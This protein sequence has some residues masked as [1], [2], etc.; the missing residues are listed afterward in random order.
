MQGNPRTRNSSHVCFIQRAYHSLCFNFARFQTNCRNGSIHCIQSIQASLKSPPSEQGIRTA[1]RPTPQDETLEADITREV[2]TTKDTIGLVVHQSAPPQ[3]QESIRKISTLR[4]QLRSIRVKPSL[5][6]ERVVL[7]PSFRV[8]NVKKE[9]VLELRHITKSQWKRSVKEWHDSIKPWINSNAPIARHCC[10]AV[11]GRAEL[12]VDRCCCCFQ[13]RSEMAVARRSRHA[14]W[15]KRTILHDDPL[16]LDEAK[17]RFA[18]SLANSLLSEDEASGCS[19]QGACFPSSSL[20]ARQTRRSKPICFLHWSLAEWAWIAAVRDIKWRLGYFGRTVAFLAYAS[21]G[22]IGCTCD[23][24]GGA[25]IAPVNDVSKRRHAHTGS[26]SRSAVS[27]VQTIDG[28]L[29]SRNGSATEI[30]QITPVHPLSCCQESQYHASGSTRS[31]RH[32]P[33][34]CP[35]HPMQGLEDTYALPISPARSR[36]GVDIHVEGG[37]LGNVR[38]WETKFPG[39]PLHTKRKSNPEL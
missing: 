13:C 36:N 26:E 11:C 6:R 24:H 15:L 22:M 5:T 34:P 38:T 20:C 10:G 14:A 27:F 31:S 25:N 30:G 4:P 9:V 18:T 21:C 29:R 16:S 33:A 37:I 17:L 1:T 19:S 7:P 2:D 35:A 8:G 3:P 23:R 28:R 32:V 39:M 12:D